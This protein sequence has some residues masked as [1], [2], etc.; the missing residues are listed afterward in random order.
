M[1]IFEPRIRNW[2]HLR[3]NS[4]VWVVTELA[5]GNWAWFQTETNTAA[6]PLLKFGDQ[7]LR[8][9]WKSPTPPR[10]LSPH[11]KKSSRRKRRS[12]A[13]TR[14]WRNAGTIRRW[15]VVSSPAM[16][17]LISPLSDHS[18]RPLLS[19]LA[20]PPANA[21]VPIYPLDSIYVRAPMWG[22]SGGSRPPPPALHGGDLLANILFELHW[23]EQ[24]LKPNP[25]QM[26]P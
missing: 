2:K 12:H 17:L 14:R 18:P 6:R 19:G 16:F 10:T 4:P 22:R 23:K 5:R 13:G 20:L 24:P 9:E 3:S 1:S 7:T 8:I 15:L 11:Q 25:L 21:H 26:K